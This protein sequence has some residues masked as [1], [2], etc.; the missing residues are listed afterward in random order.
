M[1]MADRIKVFIVDD[2]LIVRQG[3]TSML[4]VEKGI[5]VVG[6]ASNA[7]DTLS[8]I[9]K[10]VPDII[11]MDLRMPGVDGIQL[12]TMV[13]N[14]LPSCKVI[15][16]TLYDQYVGE[17]MRAGARGYLL[18]DIT[19]EDLVDSIKRVYRGEQVYD[20]RIRPTIKIDYEEKLERE[21]KDLP[22][23]EAKETSGDTLSTLLDQARVFILPPADIGVSLRLASVL[24]EALSG[25][26]RQV[27]GTSVDGISITFN[28]NRPLSAN[29]INRRVSNIP[30]LKVAEYD[31]LAGINGL[32]KFVKEKQQFSIKHPSAT[33]VFVQ[34]QL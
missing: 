5:Q 10:V 12:T 1:K 28:L 22:S 4:E 6:Q 17:A 2:H 27:E 34:L 25:D 29:E 14:A 9:T 15:V 19:L 23:V 21:K 26:F 13:R 31:A 20:N 33:T 24:E 3:I 11:L 8:Q 18:K 16:L 7:Q 32:Q 30:N